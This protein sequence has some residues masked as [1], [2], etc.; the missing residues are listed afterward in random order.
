MARPSWG[1]GLTASRSSLPLVLARSVTLNV[2]GRAGFLGVGFVAA[3]VLARVLGP[4]DRGLLGEMVAAS[5]IGLI[6]FGVGI[7]LAVTYYA[8]R[9][10]VSHGAL[11]GNSLAWTLG[12]CV[13]ILPLAWLFHGQL[14]DAFGEGRGGRVWVLAAALVPMTFLDWTT[15]NQLVGMLRFGLFNALTIL[16]RVLYL[17]AIVVLVAVLGGGV[18]AAVVATM[19]GSA[20]MVI[21]SLPTIL[22]FGRP[23]LERALMGAMTRYGA[24]VQI[25]SFLQQANARFDVL[26]LQG[27]RPLSDVGYYIVAQTIAELVLTAATAF[28]TS[29]LPL[30][31]HDDGDLGRQR[32]T[33]T[34]S[35]RHYGILAGVAT[36]FNAAFGTLV[37]LFAYGAEFHPAVLPFF[38]LLPS[39]WFLGLGMVIQGDLGG[40]GRPG[41]SSALTGLGAVA[42]VAFDLLL[43]PPFGVIGAACASVI[44]YT[45]FGVASLVALGR[46]ADIPLRTMV[47]PRRS[48]IAGYRS[49]LR[50]LPARLAARSGRA[51]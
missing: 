22:H 48:D 28:Q 27:F 23:R 9:P 38:I 17:V 32:T 41:L 14:A 33:S 40:R 19:L 18:G 44:A 49:A 24:R 3:I 13:V 2:L 30:V 47:V 43:I 5:S 10:G 31:A 1:R 42:T 51:R 35:V 34:D 21:G 29:V 37:I 6:L 12:L 15:H 20:V 25:G 11:L 16:A 45:V 39:I 26:I 50:G 46:V 7:P 8:S 36:L 4:A